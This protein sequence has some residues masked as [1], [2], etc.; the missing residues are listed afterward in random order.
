MSWPETKKNCF[1][2]S[3]CLTLSNKN[4][5]FLCGIVICDKKWIFYDNQQWPAPV[6]GPRRSSKTLPKAKLEPRE[7]HGHCL[8]VCAILIHCNFLSPCETITSEK[9]SASWWDIPETTLAAGIGQQKRWFFSTT[10]SNYMFYNLQCFKSWMNWPTKFC[11]I[12][13]IHLTF[14]QPTTTSSSNLTT[15]CRENTSPTSRKQKMLSNSSLNLKSTDFYAT[16][17]NKLISCWQKCVDCNGS[18]FD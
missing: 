11:L 8:V 16:G 10:T 15:F 4:E 18:Y 9:W 3:S 7:G 14:C 17:I 2:V 5:P 1:E 13:C 6:V 12:C